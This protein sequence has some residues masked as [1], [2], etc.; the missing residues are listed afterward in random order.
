MCD[1]KTPGV[2]ITRGDRSGDATI[3]RVARVRR[4]TTETS[5][6][7]TETAAHA[8][9]RRRCVPKPP[10]MPVRIGMEGRDGEPPAAPCG[11]G[12]KALVSVRCPDIGDVG[13][14]RPPAAANKVV[15]RCAGIRGC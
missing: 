3:V 8:S 13:I 11:P 12:P 10:R 1:S 2:A 7:T 5:G 4:R 15:R 6:R 9:T 14:K